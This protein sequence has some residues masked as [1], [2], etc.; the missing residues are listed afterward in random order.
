MTDKYNLEE[1]VQDLHSIYDFVRWSVS[2]FNGAGLYFGHGTD[3]PWDEALSLILQLLHLPPDGNEQL[4]QAR[5]TSSEKQL[6]VEKVLS[7]IQLRIPVAYLTNQAWFCGMPFFVDERVL[8]PRS[9]IA[10]LIDKQFTPWL[11][12]EPATILDLC[13]GSGC[14][15]IACAM[16]FPDAQVDAVDLSEEALAVAEINIQE[17]DLSNRVFPIQSD[18]FN[19]LTGQRYD[20]IV[21]NPPYVDAE[22]MGDLPEEFHHEPELGLAAG[23]DG[24]DLVHLILKQ[25]PQYLQDNGWLIVEVGNSQVHMQ[26]QYPELPLQWIEFENGGH[27]VFAI[28]KEA[29]IKYNK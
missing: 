27:G 4:L 19:N 16:A 26:Q 22:D 18:L 14:I 10:E 11:D 12:N 23:H 9:P 29:L 24:L 3:N 1:P 25:A 13:T 15:A 8:V 7:R 6:I 5:L 20:L 17:Y 21:T 2:R 28:S